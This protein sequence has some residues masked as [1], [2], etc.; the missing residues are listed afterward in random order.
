MAYKLFVDSDILLDLFLER[1]PYSSYTQKLLILAEENQV[2]LFT[3]SVIINNLFYFIA[4]DRN[5]EIAKQSLNLLIEIC[6]IL[7]VD[8]DVVKFALDSE[9]NDFEDALQYS[10][11]I[12]FNCDQILTRNLKHY[13]KSTIPV[14]TAEQ[15][16]RTL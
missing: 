3:S 16:L 7:P 5:K 9:F 15:F 14:L 2:K 13:K 1:S 8:E 4:R 11:A 6:K 10:T 12:K